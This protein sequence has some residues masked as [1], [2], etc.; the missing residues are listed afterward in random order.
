MQHQFVRAGL[1]KMD[2]GSTQT[3]RTTVH[4]VLNQQELV[5]IISLIHG[6]YFVGVRCNQ[7]QAGCGSGQPGL[8]V[9]DPA[10]GRG[11]K[12]DDHY[13]PFQPKPFYDSMI[14]KSS[15]IFKCMYTVEGILSMKYEYL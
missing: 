10:H 2:S 3:Q 12:L 6:V 1:R 9:G 7:G 14:L 13:G 5:S 8:V 15:A 4:S 11:L